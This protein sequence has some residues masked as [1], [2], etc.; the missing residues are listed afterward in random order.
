[1]RIQ[2]SGSE[3]GEKRRGR[4]RKQDM[5]KGEEKKEGRKLEKAKKA[6]EKANI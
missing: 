1:M 3:E 2:T 5:M 4:K 6:E